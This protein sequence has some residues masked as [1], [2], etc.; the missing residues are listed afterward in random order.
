MSSLQTCPNCVDKPTRPVF[1]ISPGNRVVACTGCGLQFAERYPDIE[2]ADHEVYDAGYFE[3]AIGKTD[4]RTDV[5]NE[6]VVEIER[7]LGRR[8]RLLD[9]G[10]GDGALLAVAAARGWQA[11]GTEISTAMVERSRHGG[12]PILREG[13]IEDIALETEAFDAVVLNHV[14]EHVR[15][16]RTT[17]EAVAR[18]LRDDGLARIEVPNIASLSARGKNLQSRLRIKPNPWKHYDT[19]HHFWFFTVDT[20]AATMRAAGL[21]VA[22]ITTLAR[23]WGRE[24][25]GE[26]VRDRLYKRTA[27]GKHIIAYARRSP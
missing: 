26:D 15:N 11:E 10:A 22:S 14:L 6:L 23:Q 24:G 2:T 12:G 13:V 9:V 27:L 1:T 8:G 7:I 25:R 3:N 17:L 4:E 5:F 19:G 20:L 16:P 18:V 21:A